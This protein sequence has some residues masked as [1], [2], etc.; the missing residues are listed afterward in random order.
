MSNRIAVFGGSFNPPSLHHRELVTALAKQFDRVI[1]VPH[2][3]RPDKPATNDVEPI[4]RAVMN[5]LAFRGIPNVRLELFDLEALTFTR[6]DEL[7]RMFASEG[8]IW[9][10]VGSDLI[11]NGS[12]GESFI[13]RVFDRG[14][15]LWESLR[16]AV[17]RR[18]GFEIFHDDL[19]PNH[20]IVDVSVEG[21]TFA[22][23][24]QAF[25]RQSLEGMVTPEVA[26]YIDRYRLYRG[27][28]V[29]NTA[30]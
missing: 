9:H 6:T 18:S 29:S 30:T 27:T 4:H 13:H 15:E 3:P 14:P 2:G 20:E 5:D 8:E 17:V 24:E 21:S 10:V 23:R 16:F 1:I 26:S 12:T 22:I 28:I 7:E 19:P 25:R 11:Q